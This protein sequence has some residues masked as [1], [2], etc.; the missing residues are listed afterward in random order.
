MDRVEILVLQ[1]IDIHVRSQDV[2]VLVLDVDQIVLHFILQYL[3][4]RLVS[5]H[6]LYLLLSLKLLRVFIALR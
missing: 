1:H 2:R 5:S 6:G 4:L 3:A